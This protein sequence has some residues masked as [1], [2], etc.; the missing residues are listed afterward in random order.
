MI[1]PPEPPATDGAPTRSIGVRAVAARAQVSLGTVSNVMNNP[2]R[3]GP[4]V[5]ARVEAAMIELGFVPSRAAGQLRSRRSSM[6][7]VVVPDVGNPYW[8]SVLRGI[9]SV[10]ERHGLALVVGSSHQDPGRQR[11]LLRGLES[12]G[13]DGLILAP[14]VARP[15]DW[16]RF[17]TR[18]FGV[19][20]LDWRQGQND[21]S[22]V[23]L[24]NVAGARLAV[25]HLLERGHRRIAFINGPLTVSWCA[26]RFEGVTAGMKEFGVDPADALVPCEVRDLTVEEGL[27]AM[28]GLVD[29]GTDATAIICANDM[30]ALGAVRSLRQRGLA[31]PQDFALVGYDDV[32]FAAALAPPLTT[33]RQPSFAVGVA[34]A[35][36]LL[37]ED[38]VLGHHVV[39]EPE[40]VVRESSDIV[41]PA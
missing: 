41:I 19:V 30:L 9:E 21:V 13:V 17:T 31:I 38:R 18:R 23:T 1:V 16:S 10:I 29:A 22:S 6:I 3:V 26:E 25:K 32:D 36:L 2:D 35:D 4:E 24:D 14:I 34:A 27:T 12:Q 33:V 7:G 15:A 40:L 28:D 11:R 20:T 37:T 5:R 8:A 39:F